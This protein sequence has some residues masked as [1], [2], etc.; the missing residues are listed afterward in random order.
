MYT[1]DNWNIL[2]NLNVKHCFNDDGTLS[3]YT[4]YPAKNY[5]LHISSLDEPVI[6]DMGN[7]TGEIKPYYTDGGATALKTYDFK[8]NPKGFEA[9]LK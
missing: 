9:I 6:D 2:P 1:A 3:H 5:V 4:I 7:E 8:T